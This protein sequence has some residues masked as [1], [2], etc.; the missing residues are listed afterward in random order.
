MQIFRFALVIVA[1]TSGRAG[2]DPKAEAKERFEHATKLFQAGRFAEALDEMTLAY[3]LDPQPDY[4][5]GIA[6]ANV[7]LGR[8]KQAITYYARFLET[9]PKPAVATATRKAI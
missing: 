9:K 2:A 6:Q 3:T 1:V 5:Y 7:R 4:L 8:C